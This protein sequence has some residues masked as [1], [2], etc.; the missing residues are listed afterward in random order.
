MKERWKGSGC[1]HWKRHQN[2]SWI[3][4]P[5]HGPDDTQIRKPC[6]PP[7]EH[8]PFLVS[9]DCLLIHLPT[10]ITDEVSYL[11][12][13]TIRCVGNVTDDGGYPV[14]RKG[15]WWSTNPQPLSLQDNITED[16][17]DVGPYYSYIRDLS[18]G[19]TYYIRAYAQNEAGTAFGDE[20]IVTTVAG[21]VPVVIT[22]AV[23]NITGSSARS[24]GTVTDPGEPQID[25]A[26]ICWS[27]SPNPTTSDN[28][29]SEGKVPAF[30]STITGLETS[31]GWQKT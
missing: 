10:V 7:R 14:T 26:G 8:H 4:R 31:G 17:S 20:V 9:P 2:I 25:D 28:H 12:Y 22:S 13:S 23:S 27:T 5:F 24:G 21:S 15:I 29:E 11:S 30:I 18:M 6:L 1:F 16:G 19:T 3:F